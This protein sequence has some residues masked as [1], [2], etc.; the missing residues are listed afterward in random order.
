MSL[1]HRP[2]AKDKW[3]GASCHNARELA[4]A[5]RIGVDFVVVSPVLPTA[6]HAQAMPLGWEGLHALTEQASVPVYA[7]GGMDES[8][9]N[10]AWDHGAQGIAGIRAW[11]KS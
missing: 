11:W 1:A 7:L 5:C 4:H 6:S 2:L 9:L 10:Q 3:V 8:M